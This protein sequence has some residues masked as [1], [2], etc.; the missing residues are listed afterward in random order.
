MANKNFVVKNG[1]TVGTTVIVD[2]SGAWVGANTGLVGATGLT[3]PSGSNGAIG[4]TGLT[5]PTG[6]TGAQGAT[7]VTGPSGSAGVAGPTGPTGPVGPTGPTGPTGATGT[8]GPTGPTGLTGP[9]GPTGPSGPTGATGAVP[10]WTKITT[11]YTASTNQ[12]L[13]ANTA[14]GAFTVTLPAGPSVGNIVK[15]TD[16]YDWT[17]NNLTV[18]GNGSTIE[19]SINDLLIDIKGVTV[20]LIYDGSTWQATAT[21]GIQGATGVS[22]WSLSGANTYYTTGGVSVGSSTLQPNYLLQ[23]NGKSIIQT[24]T[25]NTNR[26]I[27]SYS[28]I[29]TDGDESHIQ[30][31]S[32]DSGDWASSFILS[33]VPST[34]NNR[35]WWLHHTPTT[36]TNGTTGRLDFRYN[37]TNDPTLI[38]G[39]AAGATT[40]LSLLPSGDISVP[41]LL[42]ANAISIQATNPALYFNNTVGDS[43]SYDMAIRCNSDEGFV[44]YEPEDAGAPQTQNLGKEWM[45]INDDGDQYN[46]GYLVFD[47]KT[48]PGS[49]VKTTTYQSS[50]MITTG[51]DADVTYF[52]FNVTK[53]YTDS[54]L[55]V[56]GDIPISGSS[57]H[58]IYWFVSYNGSKVFS[59]VSD[60]WRV[61]PTGASP[62]GMDA[63]VPGGIS[64]TSTGAAGVAAGT[65]T[66]GFGQASLTGA[67]NR[68]YHYI[69]PNSSID[70]RNRNGTTFIV[71]EVYS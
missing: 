37:A 21:L 4:A 65:V 2:S 67:P 3:G 19:G 1:I 14:N 63:T 54:Y 20:E 51:T 9:T 71:H 26:A 56:Y 11:T 58:G 22:P 13:I 57:N 23:V 35:H 48:A 46:F 50:T 45:R 52:T 64:V 62:Y 39:D 42:T 10:G 47:A 6:P 55:V 41:K 69:N 33:N 5:G 8:V 40:A 70:G 59:G 25:T 32:S 27:G 31:M 44:I 17:A 16:G 36:I 53:K 7:G 60:G 30:I 28:T 43:G 49:I 34:G 61:H 24:S 66:I 68:P 18:A 38:G 29:L 12:Q 15:I